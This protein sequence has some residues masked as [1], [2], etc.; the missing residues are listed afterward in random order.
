MVGLNLPIVPRRG[1]I[2]VTE[3]A[4]PLW[5]GLILSADYLLSK[6][7]PTAGANSASKMLSGVVT[8]QVKRGNCLI[9]STRCFAGFDIRN[10]YEGIQ[11][12]VRNSVRLIPLLAGL[13]IIRSYAGLRPATPDGL[14]IIEGSAELPGFITAAGHEGDAVC[15]GPMTG[16]LLAELVTGEIGAQVLAPFAS[17]RFDTGQGVAGDDKSH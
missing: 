9:G 12:L 13:H 17:H 3:P 5:D 8:N 2:L 1:Q 11:A 14:P 16:K 6:K 15:L 10:T 4:P 7:M